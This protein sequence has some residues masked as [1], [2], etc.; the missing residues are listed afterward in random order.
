[1]PRIVD[2]AP[3]FESVG[4]VSSTEAL[5]CVILLCDHE[6]IKRGSV[7]FTFAVHMLASAA[8][9]NVGFGAVSEKQS[10]TFVV[11]YSVQVL[12]R[13]VCKHIIGRS[14]SSMEPVPYLSFAYPHVCLC[15]VC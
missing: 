10:V 13:N 2:P 4:S 5:C 1:M 14:M 7:P 3:C 11:R 15:C 9:F 8:H 12:G 6:C